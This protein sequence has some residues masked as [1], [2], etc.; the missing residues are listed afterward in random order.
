[1]KKLEDILTEKYKYKKLSIEKSTISRTL[2]ETLI[3]NFLQNQ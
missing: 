1:M 3:P 2:Y